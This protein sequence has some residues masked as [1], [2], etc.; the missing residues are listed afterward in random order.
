MHKNVALSLV[1]SKAIL[2]ISYPCIKNLPKPFDV[3]VKDNTNGTINFVGFI[4]IPKQKKERYVGKCQSQN[5][6]L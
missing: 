5:P 2:E 1:K 3:K 6:F 4:F